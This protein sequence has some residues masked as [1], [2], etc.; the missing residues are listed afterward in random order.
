ML[1]LENAL[2]IPFS[3]IRPLRRTNSLI[4]FFELID[5]LYISAAF[6]YP[7]HVWIQKCDKYG[8]FSTFSPILSELT[9]KLSTIFAENIGRKFFSMSVNS[10]IHFSIPGSMTLSSNWPACDAIAT[11]SISVSSDESNGCIF[12]KMEMCVAVGK[13]SLLDCHIFTWSFGLIT[14][15]SPFFLP[16]ISKARLAITSF[17]FILNVVLAPEFITSS[18]NW[19][20]S[21][22]QEFRR[23]PWLHWPWQR[24]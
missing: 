9:F 4:D 15:Y 18:T 8:F 3:V 1:S 6:K 22:P 16:K 11:D 13:I 17:E 7:I 24:L 20:T 10:N 14:V 23:K 5:S 2:F 19:S 12:N 21:L